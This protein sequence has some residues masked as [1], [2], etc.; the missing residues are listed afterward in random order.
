MCE[1]LK[2][3]VFKQPR[4]K[5]WLSTTLFRPGFPSAK[6]TDDDKRIFLEKVIRYVTVAIDII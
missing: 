4:V 6:V 3:M 2:K 1:V 5:A